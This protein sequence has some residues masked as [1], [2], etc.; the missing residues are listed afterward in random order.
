MVGYENFWSVLT[1]CTAQVQRSLDLAS[2]RGFCVICVRLGFFVYPV[3]V[4][5]MFVFILDFVFS[6]LAKKLAG[7]SIS[8]MTSF[9]LSGM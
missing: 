5:F 7:N 6:V 8:K 4:F 1:G 3:S 9:V 2:S